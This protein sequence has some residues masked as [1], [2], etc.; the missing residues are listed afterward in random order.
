M[1]LLVV[2]RRFLEFRPGVW[3]MSGDNHRPC[4]PRHL[5]KF[6]GPNGAVSTAPSGIDSKLK[7]PIYI[8]G[9]ALCSNLATPSFY[10]R[11][12]LSVER[13]L[14]GRCHTRFRLP[15]THF[16]YQLLIDSA[17]GFPAAPPGD[18][19]SVQRL[20]DCV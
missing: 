14:L 10:P 8:L 12:K 13:R 2:L 7:Y 15:I 9:H 11:I 3:V 5:M 6:F 19:E 18:Y 1:S 16:L 4:L 20:D 17:D